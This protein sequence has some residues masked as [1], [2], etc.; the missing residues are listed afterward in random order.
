M[1]KQ[2]FIRFNKVYNYLVNLDAKRFTMRSFIDGR[3]DE[4]GVRK[5]FCQTKGDFSAYLTVIFPQ[6]WHIVEEVV[7]LLKK[8]TTEMYSKDIARYF[9]L[10]EQEVLQLTVAKNYRKPNL[11]SVLT[12]MKMLAKT[13][14][15]ALRIERK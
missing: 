2:Q 1:N 9:G 7:P 10:A 8:D 6:D 15:H 3:V 13:Y 11:E 12:R 4:L 14:G 5:P